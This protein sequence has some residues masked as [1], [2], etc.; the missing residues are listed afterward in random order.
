[1]PWQSEGEIALTEKS[2][3]VITA[4]GRV[5][6]V[7][8]G[9][10]NIDTFLDYLVDE[11]GTPGPVV[12]MTRA[13]V[14]ARIARSALPTGFPEADVVI[15]D[16]DREGGFTRGWMPATVA[17]WE[18]ATLDSTAA[19]VGPVNV[20]PQIEPSTAEEDAAAAAPRK[21]T[22]TPAEESA[23]PGAADAY[24]ARGRMCGSRSRGCGQTGRWPRI[25]GSSWQQAGG[26]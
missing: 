4:S 17:A 18:S 7:P 16:A 8:T 11:V 14:L 9:D 24:Y 13:Q 21:P 12:A 23:D 20:A 22:S 26:S 19:V 5:A 15:G 6:A 1:M 2:H 25:S 10:D 3:F